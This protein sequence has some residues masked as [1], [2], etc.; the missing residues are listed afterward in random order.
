M[1]SAA[2]IENW[3]ENDAD[4]KI[5]YPVTRSERTMSAKH[6]EAMETK[7][8]QPRKHRQANMKEEGIK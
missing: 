2:V 8:Q 7:Y 3:G 1:L 4:F 6:R 5:T